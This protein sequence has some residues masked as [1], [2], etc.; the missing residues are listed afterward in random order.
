MLN[1]RFDKLLF[2]NR[3]DF[4]SDKKISYIRNSVID[5]NIVVLKS[6][7]KKKMI[8]DLFKKI[9]KDSKRP[10]KNTK[11][12][13]G[14]KNIYYRSNSSGQG[15]YSTFD[16]NWY[17][18]P[19][20][21][22]KYG[23]VDMVQKYF[24]RV[25]LFNEY[26]IEKIKKN[27]PKDGIVQRFHLLYYPLKKGHISAH[28]DPTNITKITCGIYITSFKDDYDEGGFYVLNKN[29]TKEF[30]DHKI[31]SGDL[32]LFYN[33]LVHGVEKILLKEN[34]KKNKDKING[35]V[36]LNLSILETHEIKNRKTTTGVD[37]INLK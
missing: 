27:T 10:Q 5:G 6:A 26:K 4:F 16:H 23:L 14:I 21:S 36:F 25:I 35:R 19:W 34:T 15:G 20:N 24:D 30:V 37:I 31:N 3:K 22:D 12:L 32:I 11:M 13:E 18:F 2:L 33:G 7:F 9:Y 1:K 29:N 8:R 28:K 17:F